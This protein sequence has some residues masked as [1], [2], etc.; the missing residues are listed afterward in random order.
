MAAAAVPTAPSTAPPPSRR[1]KVGTTR[2]A[3]KSVEETLAGFNNVAA[4]MSET[5]EAMEAV[6]GQQM[7]ASS[8]TTGTLAIEEYFNTDLHQLGKEF[9][10][11]ATGPLRGTTK[12]GWESSTRHWHI[13]MDFAKGYHKYVTCAA[14]GNNTDVPM[15]VWL[16][17]VSM[18]M[19]FH[20]CVRL[21]GSS[22]GAYAAMLDSVCAYGIDAAVKE[23]MSKKRITI[24]EQHDPRVLYSTMHRKMKGIIKRHYGMKV[25]ETLFI[26]MSEAKSGHKFAD[27][28]S[29]NGLMDAALWNLSSTSGGRRGRSLCSVQL[30]HVK[31][32][33]QAVRVEGM[34]WLVPSFQFVFVDEKCMDTRGPRGMR[35]NFLGW[36]NYEKDA[37][38][39]ASI[40]CYQLFCARGAFKVE[41]PLLSA[42]HGADMEI[43]EEC[44][45]W[46]LF[47]EVKGGV[48]FDSIPWTSEMMST[49]TRRI[50]R[51]M[52]TDERGHRAHRKGVASRA[53]IFDLIKNGGSKVDS[54]MLRALVFLGGWSQKEGEQTMMEVYVA[55]FMNEYLD[56]FNLVYGMP[57]TTT[58]IEQRL[59]EFVGEELEPAHS[60][61]NYDWVGGRTKALPWLVKIRALRK[62]GG[63]RR[64]MDLVVARMFEAVGAPWCRGLLMPVNRYQGARD[65]LH[66]ACKLFSNATNTILHPYEAAL[67]ATY[68]QY[69]T[70][71]PSAYEVALGHEM[72]L[73]CEE[74]SACAE[75]RMTVKCGVV[76]AASQYPLCRMVL[77]A[78]ISVHASNAW[79]LNG[80]CSGSEVLSGPVTFMH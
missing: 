37:F 45:E 9:A 29:L 8:K 10:A 13:Y 61:D 49:S 40:Y 2:G 53:V 73:I 15:V 35:E 69:E 57:S 71:L 7:P 28:R 6:D 24:Q 80:G 22:M 77:D 67:V 18:W 30:K 46:Y 34:E 62:L 12:Q 43:R 14:T 42:K 38:L 5:L 33:V 17:S 50:C 58:M 44:L 68:N 51:R 65:L 63:C 47:Y 75:V 32:T 4:Q 52:E 72:G 1:Q 79:R 19:Q 56:S 60:Y 48:C 3:A 39:S 16:P 54:D 41:F 76:S 11:I 20:H 66:D 78:P 70:M 36:E 64:G 31:V 25:K 23:Q 21:R 55:G 74:Y 26:S 59:A 27:M